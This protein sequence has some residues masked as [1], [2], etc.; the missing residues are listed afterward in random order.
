[1][2]KA[3]K[4]VFVMAMSCVLV[5][6]MTACGGGGDTTTIEFRCETSIN[7][8]TAYINAIRTY[9]NG[10]GKTDGVYVNAAYDVPSTSI[11]QQISSYS[12]QTPNVVC[13]DDENFKGKASLGYFLSLDSYLT[14]DVKTSMDWENIP[15]LMI[16]RYSYNTEIDATIGKKTAGKGTSVLGLPN[17]GAPLVLFYNE[18]ML[19]TAGVNIISITENEISGTNYQPHGYAEYKTA[20]A[21]GLTASTNNAGQTVYKVFNNK[22]PMNWEEFRYLMKHLQK[23]LQCEYPYMTEWWF[24]Y[25]WSIGGDC[26]GWDAAQGEYVFTLNDKKTNFLVVGNTTINGVN[27]KVGDVLSYEDKEY[28]HNHS[29]LIDN[30]VYELPSMYDAFL[31]FNRIGVPKTKIV[32]IVDNTAKYGYGFANPTLTNREA[33]FKAGVSPFVAANYN[34]ISEF[35]ESNVKNKFDIAPQQ[36]YREYEQGSLVNENAFEDIQVKVIGETYNGE[37]YNGE[38]KKVNGTAIVGRAA[39]QS[40]NYCI[41]I[42]KNSDPNK[43]DAAFKFASWLA[44]PEAQKLLSDGNGIIP[45]QTNVA[46]DGNFL[47]DSHRIIDN[48]WAAVYANENA[49]M[50]DWAYFDEGSWVTAWA[51]LLN[52]SV[53]Q[54]N[55]TLTQFFNLEYII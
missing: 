33:P 18:E 8:K 43:Y 20:P 10:Q 4:K 12:P 36:Q 46:Y 48:T 28:L 34:Q 15:E 19:A 30:N 32:D 38:L 22:I 52:T 2:I 26:I 27:Y 49:D 23:T 44:G 29:T 16:N 11:G 13:M 1:M 51:D 9:N 17:G 5:C 40:L 7:E 6:G 24:N 54:G 55:I 37:T 45:N 53:R 14:D 21:D 31:E 39:T 35:Q 50:G 42:A 41:A 3:I 47:N 25:G